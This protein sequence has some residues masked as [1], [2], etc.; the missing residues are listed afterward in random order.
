MYSLKILLPLENRMLLLNFQHLKLEQHPETYSLS[1][2]LLFKLTSPLY[3]G[4][5]KEYTDGYAGCLRAL[6]LNGVPVDLTN[7]VTK[8]PWGLYGVHLGCKGK[9]ER[10]PCKNNG[11]CLEGYDHFKC[12]CRWT[13]FKEIY[14]DFIILIVKDIISI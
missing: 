2:R 11:E 14:Q 8:N 4:A 10:N 13:P 1:L 5:T 9:C 12:N 6:V 7:E 3:V